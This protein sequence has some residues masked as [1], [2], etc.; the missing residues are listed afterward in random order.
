MD[1][2]SEE[3][4]M[5]KRIC[6]LIPLL[7]IVLMQSVMAQRLPTGRYNANRARQY[8][9]IHYKADLSFDFQK[10]EIKGTA[11][12]TLSPLRKLET[13]TIDAI[14]LSVQAVRVAG[15]AASFIIE[16]S[17]IEIALP[18]HKSPTDTL[19]IEVVY[20]ARPQAGVYFLKDP[21]AR[22][23]Y[24]VTT[25]GESG[26]HAN[27][28]PIFS[29]VNDR[30]STEL[31]LT[32]P[33]A[34][35]AISNGKLLSNSEIG[36]RMRRFHWKQE[37]PH[38]NYLIAFYIGDFEKGSL[39]PAFGEI[40]LSYWVPRGQLAHGEYV[41]RNST[42]MVEFFSNRFGFR[43]PWD[44]Y[45]QIAMPDYPIGA[46]EHTSVTG[47]DASLL[48]TA[49]GSRDFSPTLEHYASPWSDEAIIAH[50]L[51]HHW[52]GNLVTCRNLSYLWL[53]ESF[54]TFLMFLW[55]EEYFGEDQYNLSLSLAREAYFKYVAEENIIRPL[56]Y[57]YFDSSN[58]IYNTEHTYFKGGAILHMMRRF[59]G[60][61]PFFAA[62]SAYL[63]KHQWGNVTSTDLRT[64]IE[65]TTGENLDWFFDDWITGAG[66]PRFKVSYDYIKE[67]DLVVLNVDQVQA[68]V[69]GQDLFA[70]PVTVSLATADGTTWQ[71]DLWID[72]ESEHFTLHSPQE[73]VMVS[74][75]G[76][77]DLVAEIEFAKTATE[78]AYQAMHDDLAGRL[79]AIA[80][81]AEHHANDNRTS[82]TYEAILR[83]D[84]FWGLRAE[85][86]RRIGALGDSSAASLIGLA[87]AS[88]DY[89]I[90][91]AAVLAL[92]HFPQETGD[93]KLSEI[94][95]TDPHSDV[96][97]TAIV[98]LGK[99]GTAVS[100]KFLR[101]QLRRESWHDE[102]RLACM[103]ACEQLARK[104]LVPT[105]KKY[106]DVTFNQSVRE[107]AVKAWAVSAPEDTELHEI[108][109]AL[110]RDH[111]YPLQQR[112][113]ALLGDL[114]VSRASG[115]LQQIVTEGADANLVSAA[116]TALHKL[117]IIE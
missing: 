79:W 113:I 11:T 82:A 31:I 101:D 60:D 27:W 8:D 7:I 107:A 73:P 112:A 103:M 106:V 89:R 66:H 34:Y 77:G 44:K 3:L 39:P 105:I 56:E 62:I 84:F 2:I 18:G 52:F 45:D 35:V 90:R 92:G 21:A 40:P 25:Y 64:A 83:S 100:E 85:V 63:R 20:S 48:R 4:V 49:G 91:K 28:L 115:R 22:D 32:V 114:Y 23:K 111:S 57:R 71:E 94:V 95:A 10:Q 81:M 29:D 67:R 72:E 30:F 116:E 80:Q 5:Y 98:S 15:R 76:H 14:A 96:V 110:T 37:L 42:R 104:D 54:A 19:D 99:L 9:L 59:L 16:E 86:A 26:L 38:P 55:D 24:F 12:L 97:A 41:F 74:F 78:L 117:A 58:T 75:D 88:D 93:A 33:A 65:E 87:L 69:E 70:L 36:N 51:A 61:E 102:I 13:L 46:M 109:I 43:F 47:H 50:E 6:L 1:G 17:S 53:N 108:L 68:L